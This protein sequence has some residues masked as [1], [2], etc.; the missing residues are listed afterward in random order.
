MIK[1]FNIKTSYNLGK[2]FEKKAADYLKKQGWQV[3]IMNYKTKLGEI[4][5]L[6]EKANTLVAF[7]V[8][9]R[10]NESELPYVILPRQQKRIQ[11]ALLF[12]Q[13]NNA[14]YNNY[15]L[16]LDAI[17]ISKSG[18]NHIENAWEEII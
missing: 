14:K 12:F 16:R 6:A 1:L 17:L 10:E 11:N 8:K 5:I 18:I 7:E 13:Q 15:Y 3:I 2:S 9:Y 4:D